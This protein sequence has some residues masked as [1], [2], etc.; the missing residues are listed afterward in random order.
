[1]ADSWQLAILKAL[2]TH[3][4]GI[5]PLNGYAYDMSTSVFRGRLI[6]GED[7]PVP[8]ISI[9]E[10]LAADVTVDVAGLENVDRSETWVLLVQGWVEQTA[11]HP[12]DDAYNLKAATELR[13]S[14]CIRMDDKTG[15]AMFPDA[16]MLGFH[17]TAIKGM[18]I[19]PGVVSTAN[20]E[21]ASNKAFF[22]LPVGIGLVTTIYEPFA[23]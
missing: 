6:F 9:V 22:Y 15:D 3:L 2:T 7:D 17:K 23:P 21:T 14:E 19:G 16:Y 18:S 10:H 20:R 5:T 1:M 12:T 13:L 4:E 11:G 8:L